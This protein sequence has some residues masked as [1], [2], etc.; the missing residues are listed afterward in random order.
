V[1]LPYLIQ[2]VGDPAL[3]CRSDNATS[4]VW[5][6]SGQGLTAPEQFEPYNVGDPFNMVDIVDGTQLN[7]KSVGGLWCAMAPISLTRNGIVCDKPNILSAYAFTYSRGT[8]FD[9]SQPIMTDGYGWP[10]YFG[11]VFQPLNTM[12]VLGPLQP[13]SPPPPPPLP[14]FGAPHACR[15]P[16][17]LPASCLTMQPL[18]LTHLITLIP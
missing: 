1:G 7:L 18:L 15:P 3:A 4:K 10:A 16:P 17:L 8:V 14:P 5:C 9:G 11:S 12:L 2:D 13:P 6:T